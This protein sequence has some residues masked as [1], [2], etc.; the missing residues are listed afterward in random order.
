MLPLDLVEAILHGIEEILVGI[1]NDA[2]RRELDDRLGFR[3]GV[4]RPDLHGI[5]PTKE[6]GQHWE[7]HRSFSSIKFETPFR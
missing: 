2:V 4:E 5:A 3:K 6:P 1:L 7:R